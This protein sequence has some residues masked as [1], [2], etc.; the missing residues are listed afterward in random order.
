ML[1]FTRVVF[2]LPPSPFLLNGVI[3]QHLETLEARYPKSIQEIRKSLYVDDL[4]SGAP[5]T[6]ESK[7][8]KRD[9]IEIFDDVKFKLHKWHSNVS[10]LESDSA[11]SELT[12]AKQ[13]LERHSTS[14]NSKLLGLPWDKANDSLCVVFP[15]IPAVLT[16]RGILAYLAKVYDPLG[17]VSPVLLEGKL[18]Y[19]DICEAKVRWDA[20]VPDAFLE[21]WQKWEQALPSTVCFARSV[22]AYQEQ[23]REVKLHSFGDASKQGTVYAVV[24]KD[25]GVVQ[26]LV[27]TRSRLA[28]SNLTIP[29]LEL[30]TWP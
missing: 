17:L 1:R 26:G 21:R 25:S 23:I 19:R 29:R 13:Q 16:K 5:T 7:E 2:G 18:I 27:A 12:F 30:V 4:I 10:E 24:K 28:K 20:T 14:A 8:L 22:A 9:A 3:Q 6:E 15:T 11:E